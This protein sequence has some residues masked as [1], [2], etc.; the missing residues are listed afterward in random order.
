MKDICS[1]PCSQ[2]FAT[3][4]YPNP[5]TSSTRLSHYFISI[6]FSFITH[7]LLGRPS[8]FFRQTFRS[9]FFG[10]HVPHVLHVSSTKSLTSWSEAGKAVD[11]YISDKPCNN[12]G[13]RSVDA[14]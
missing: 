3:V 6:H 10:S 8:D 14:G 7:L 11:K 13:I 5:Y 12:A 1:L 9:K 2:K 4:P